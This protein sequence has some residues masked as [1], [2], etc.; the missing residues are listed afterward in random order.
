MANNLFEDFDPVS[1]KQWKQKI[2]FELK[3]ADYNETLIW[4]SPEDIK[5]KP[6]YHKD[7]FTK[8]FPVT[9]KASECKICQNIFVYDIEKSIERALDSINRGAESLR[10]TIENDSIDI[11]K[12]LAKLPLEKVTIYFNLTF[13]SID[14]V[15]K[16]ET[17]AKEK[18]ATIFCNLDPIGQLA[19]DGNWFVTKEKNNFETLN[20]LSKE[21]TTVSLLSINAALYQ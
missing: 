8:A 4:N 7:E 13:L 12:L 18:N 10:F 6:F 20:L 17:I 3:G 11:E 1:S 15:K 16:I 21:T 19:K 5:V 14:F 2:Q 9:S